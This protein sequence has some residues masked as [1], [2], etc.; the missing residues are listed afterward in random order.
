[1]RTIC[2]LFDDFL[3]SSSDPEGGA[4][5]YDLHSPD[6]PIRAPTGLA[7]ARDVA[8]DEFC[9]QHRDVTLE[10]QDLLP[11]FTRT[12]YYGVSAS[13]HSAGA[14][15]W[16]RVLET[17]T[18]VSCYVAFG[19]ANYEE[20]H[21]VGWCTIAP[22]ISSWSYN[23]GLL[24]SLANFAWMRT[25]SDVRPRTLLDASYRRF[26]AHD[27][28]TFLT[29]PNAR[30]SCQMSATCCR[31]DFEINLPAEAQLIIDAIH[32]PTVAPSVPTTALPTLPNG[33]LHLKSPHEKCRFLSSRNRC[34]IHETVGTQ[35][36]AP[37]A[38]F[39]FRFAW[40]PDGISA[41]TSSV[42]PSVRANVGIP[43]VDR[44]DDLRERLAFTNPPRP[45]GFR[46]TSDREVSW[47]QFRQI[48]ASICE[49]LDDQAIPLRRRLY[50]TATI[51]ERGGQRRMEIDPWLDNHA[52][53]LLP[54][55]RTKL[56]ELFARVLSIQRPVLQTLGGIV[57]ED[58]CER[59]TRFPVTLSQILRNTLFSKVFSYKFD[60]TTAQNL[61]VVLYLVALTMEATNGGALSNAMWEELGALGV[62]GLLG[63][64][65][66]PPGA[67]SKFRDLLGMPEFGVWL[68]AI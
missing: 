37:C 55:L 42:C 68:L 63:S 13:E 16:F 19:I 18:N 34:L 2:D 4:R 15:A 59:E 44:T 45:T 52:V 51:L 12:A 35:P 43:I 10:A 48:E 41:A 26:H 60:M 1:M 23:D 36:F 66:E 6:A 50:R 17:H 9:R 28:T 24:K 14:I 29:L 53:V 21:R 3:G 5:L 40:T 49:C 65:L 11:H 8:R 47:T 31:N 32:W 57:P 38:V 54:D 46:L 62:H 61:L 56:R 20:G 22:H 33:R 25:L 39:P 7:L 64:L 27:A 58:L 67:L 30:F